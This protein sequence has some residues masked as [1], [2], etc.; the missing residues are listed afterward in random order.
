MEC[1]TFDLLTTFYND[2]T[3]T[4]ISISATYTSNRLKKPN[5]GPIQKSGMDLTS[6]ELL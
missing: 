2:A 3:E 4:D 5:R 6:L 1:M